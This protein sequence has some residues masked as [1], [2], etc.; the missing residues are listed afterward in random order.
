MISSTVYSGM[1]GCFQGHCNWKMLIGYTLNQAV[2]IPARLRQTVKTHK[3]V[4]QLMSSALERCL[5]LSF[6][7]GVLT[8]TLCSCFESWARRSCSSFTRSCKQYTDFIFCIRIQVPNFT[9]CGVHGLYVIPASTWSSTLNFSLDNGSIPIDG[10]GI[11]LYPEVS[12]TDWGQLG[13]SNGNW[14]LWKT[15]RYDR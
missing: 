7:F 10:V 14:W 12:C 9:A 15:V 8:S 5:Q 13:W 2:L 11:Q 4:N 3:K 6:H 1:E